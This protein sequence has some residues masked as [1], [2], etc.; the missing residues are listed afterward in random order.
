MS[1]KGTIKK[2]ITKKIEKEIKKDPREWPPQCYGLLYQ[3]KRPE[4]H[5]VFKIK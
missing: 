5:D 3:P 1:V 2:I 4:K